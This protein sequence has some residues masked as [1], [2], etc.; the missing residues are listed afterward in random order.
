VSVVD[1]ISLAAAFGVTAW[2]IKTVTGKDR[3]AERYSEDDARTFIDEHGHWPDETP[4]QAAERRKRAAESERIAR[5]AYR[6][7]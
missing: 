4:E 7:G 1:I 6:G 2:F 5:S 3:D